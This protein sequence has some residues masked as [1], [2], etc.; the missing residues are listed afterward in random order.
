MIRHTVTLMTTTDAS[1]YGR[2]EVY[3]SRLR[4]KLESAAGD[5]LLIE[6]VRGKGYRL[7]LPLEAGVPVPVAPGNDGHGPPPSPP[8][9]P[10]AG[11]RGAGGS[12]TA[13]IPS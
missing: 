2:L 5:A 8:P 11:R 12:P 7:M 4:R 13:Y 10:A 9:R 1:P 6:T 3:V